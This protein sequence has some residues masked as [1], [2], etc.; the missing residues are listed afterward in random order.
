MRL[1]MAD[2][3]LGK[4]RNCSDALLGSWAYGYNLGSQ[5]TNVTR[6][7]SSFVNYAYDPL[8]QVKT[9]LGKEGAGATRWHE[10]FG[11]AYDAAGNLNLRTNND[12][13][14]AFNVNSLNELSTVSRTT[15]MTVAGTTTS[16][17]TNVTVNGLTAA[18][19][20][21]YTFA[22][23]NIG[24]VEGNNIFTAVARD[25]YGR[26]DTS[27]SIC[28]LPSTNSY[29]YD[30]DGNLLTDGTRNFAYGD[31]NQLTSVWVT[32]VWRSGFVYDGKMRRRIRREYTW[33][34]GSWLLASET[35]YIHD[36]MLVIQERD[37]NNLPQV[38]YTRGRDLSGSLQG[39]GGIGGLLARTSNSDLLS[40]ISS[41]TAHAFYH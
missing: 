31:E 34:S 25:S 15:N 2:F 36:G 11:Y 8:G 23:T 4:L 7:D 29:T 10:Q 32:N 14:Q 13:V 30:L 22:R 19:Y 5:R 39:A 16:A 3:V 28:Y 37:G 27:T 6:T 9:A 35:R 21:D 17:A 20:G 18:L 24:L 12:L 41:S 38:T 33:S 26:V 40:S 1:F